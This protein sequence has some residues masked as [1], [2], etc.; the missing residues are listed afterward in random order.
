M[1][2][3]KNID[4]KY[5]W[6]LS[7]IYESES[8][9]NAEYAKAEALIRK[10]KK[11]EKTMCSGAETFCETLAAFA[12]IDLIVSRLW[13]YASLNFALDTSDN[14][15][16]AMTERVRSLAVSAGE[17]SWFFTPYIL[18]LDANLVESWFSE[19]PALQKY[20]RMIEKIMRE[21]PYMLS[22]DCEKLM[23]K[24][25]DCL[26]THS[27][28]RSIF[29][30]SDM[31]LGKIKNESGERIELTDAN[32]ITNLMSRDRAVRR[33]AFKAMYRAYGQFANTCGVLFA[34]RIKEK[35]TLASVRGHESSLA[36]STFSD[37]LTPDIYNNLIDAVRANLQ[38]LYRYYELKRKLLGL[39]KLHMYDLYVPLVSNLEREYSYEESV[40]EVLKTVKVLGEEYHDTLRDGLLTKR[41]A[42]V[43]PTRGKR[44]GAFSSG[45]YGTEPYILLNFNGTYD[46]V[47]TLAHEAGHSMH[48]WFSN[49]SNE[50]HDSSYTLFVAEVASTVNELLL[51]HRKLRESKSE[52]EKLYILNTLMELYKSTL[53]R[54]TMFAEFEREMHALTEKGE[55]LTADLI[56]KRYYRLVRAYFGKDVVCDKDISGE[57]MRVPH[58][59]TSFYVYKYATSI[60]AASAIVKRIEEEGDSYVEKYLDFLRCGDSKSPLESLLVAGIDMTDPKVVNGAIEDFIYSIA[61]FE[62][63]YEKRANVL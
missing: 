8:L 28:I 21:K 13:Q 1:L 45:C 62:S 41:W 53:Y 60:S 2:D 56:S 57:W 50:A 19:Y 31:R 58:F 14:K 51:A 61:Q 54:Q 7:D 59:Y 24:M 33:S 55:P 38:P 63:I 6:N 5:K 25:Q 26:G 32:Y 15:Y 4:K 11:F 48:T 23:A 18:K 36:A 34:S 30:N 47:S 44:S 29:V 9:F 17:A 42:D 3:R 35:T 40:E 27:N 43:Y 16:Q 46:D 20:R 10:F 12:E 22:D 39:E 49:G 52:D 37:E